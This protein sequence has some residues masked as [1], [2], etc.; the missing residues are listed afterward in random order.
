MINGFDGSSISEEVTLTENLTSIDGCDSTIVWQYHFIPIDTTYIDYL[1]C[2]DDGYEVSLGNNLY[3]Q[4]NNTGE[5]ILQNIVGCDSTIIVD[6]Q[7]L[8]NSINDTTFYYC[9]DTSFEIEINGTLYNGVNDQGTEL[10]LSV[11]GCDSIVNIEVVELENSIKDLNYNICEKEEFSVNIGNEIF[12]ENNVEGIVILQTE[13]GC[14]SIISVLIEVDKLDTTIMDL[15]ICTGDSLFFD[16]LFFTSAGLYDIVYEGDNQ[17]DSIVLI[18][19][20]NL[21]CEF[22]QLVD[23]PYTANALLD[24]FEFDIDFPEGYQIVWSQSDLLSCHNC[25]NPTLYLDGSNEYQFDVT[26]ICPNNCKAKYTLEVDVESSIFTS[27]IFS[28]SAAQEKDRNFLLSAGKLFMIE[29]A[30][31]YDRWG[32]LVYTTSN[33]EVSKD[34]FT[35]DGTDGFGNLIEQG[36]YVYQFNI[37]FENNNKAQLIGDFTIIH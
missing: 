12:D 19:V 8:E 6:L 17:C 23:A 16:D 4:T 32:N 11:E 20:A 31:I 18:N 36:V 34:G 9:E 24:S 25:Q 28:P 37:L 2:V 30:R 5:V 10:F 33:T 7:Y 3:N 13:Q 21:I 29:Q 22:P 15:D 14:D 35:W 27:N 1:G 26:V